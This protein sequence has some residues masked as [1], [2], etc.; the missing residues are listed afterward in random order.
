ML[1]DN[2]NL[3]LLRIFESVYRLESMTRAAEELHMT[4]SGVS[5]N[6]KSLEDILGIQLFDRVKQRPIPTAKARVLFQQCSPWL[7]EVEKTLIEVTDKTHVIRGEVRLGLPIEFGNNVVLKR[8]ASWSERYPEISFRF[9]YDL[10]PRMNEDLLRGELD[11][12]I[13]DDFSFDGHLSVQQ[14]ATETLALCL[15]EGYLK[16]HKMPDWSALSRKKLD[17]KFFESLRYLDYTEETPILQSWF[18]H[19]YQ[20]T[21]FKPKL[22]A[23]LMDVQGIARMIIAD[24]GAGVLPLHVVRRLT[25]QEFKVHYFEGSGVPLLNRLNIVKLKN[26]TLSPAAQ[27]THDFLVEGL[28]LREKEQGL[29]LQADSSLEK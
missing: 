15:S 14:V 2:L 28:A 4:Q 18:Q 21:Q 8:L 3:N 1:I 13:V 25:T 26:R 5:Q 27:A 23:S 24:M 9:R 29:T 16:K 10:A 19:H 11:F 12:A 7:R 6:I 17:K 20:F 22:V